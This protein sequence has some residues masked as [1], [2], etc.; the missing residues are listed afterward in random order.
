MRFRHS[1]DE[2]WWD[3]DD[4]PVPDYS[5]LIC[6]ELPVEEAAWDG[7]VDPRGEPLFTEAPPFGFCSQRRDDG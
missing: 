5:G 3:F 7:L 1:S 4:P 6:V 2:D